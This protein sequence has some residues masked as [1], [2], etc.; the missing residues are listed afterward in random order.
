MSRP[1]IPKVRRTTAN[2]LL[3]GLCVGIMACGTVRRS[4]GSS[5]GD[6]T[7]SQILAVPDGS[8]FTLLRLLRP[9]WLSPRLQATP[10]DPRPVYPY[11]YVDELLYGTLESLSRISTN[12]IERIEFLSALD[13]TTRYGTGYMGG[14][15][16][17]ITRSR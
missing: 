12:D 14:I 9:R 13:A 3:L 8:A 1:V 16:R 2:L 11:V 10:A 5:F 6:I 7:R 4:S 15:I 17:V